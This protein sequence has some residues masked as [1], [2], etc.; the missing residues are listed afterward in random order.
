MA[1]D[2]SKALHRSAVVSGVAAAPLMAS[3]MVIAL[4]PRIIGQVILSAIMFAA[5]IAIG[6]MALA[7]VFL[8]F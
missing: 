1:L 4:D 6:L 8:V 3:I 2:P 7:G 5:R